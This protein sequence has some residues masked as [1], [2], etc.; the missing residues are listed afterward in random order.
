MRVLVVEDD[1]KVRDLLRRG[2]EELT[3]EQ[4]GPSVAAALA[5]LLSEDELALRAYACGLLA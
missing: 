1:P 3:D 4:P 2:L 5:E